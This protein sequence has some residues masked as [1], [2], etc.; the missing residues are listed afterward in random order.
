MK[1][2][3]LNGKLVDSARAN[4]SIFDRGLNYGD[5]LLETMLAVDGRVLFLKEHLKRL[6]AGLKELK[7]K[8]P[9]LDALTRRIN[10]GIIEKLL[11][12][13][14]LL[15]GQAYMRI[16][17]TRGID[18][19]SVLPR[20]PL[21]PTVIIVA[22]PIDIKAAKARG[23]GVAAVLLKDW[24]PAIPSVKTLNYLPN[25]LGKMEAKKRGA[26]EG[27]FTSGEFVLEG[28]STNIFVIKKGVLMTPPL[29]RISGCGILP[30]ITRDVIMRLARANGLKAREKRLRIKD[31]LG[32]EEAF[33]TNSIIGVAPLVKVDGLRVGTGKPGEATRL[34]QNAYGAV[35][36]QLI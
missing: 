31:L 4:I 15:K 14:G 5:G 3:Y 35:T 30:G 36:G 9:A 13:N 24:R 19:G 21:D 7:I 23:S 16:T 1:K 25:L 22:K 26:S 20:G 8:G 32:C 2:V 12:S 17:V 6:G 28:S 11:K 10:G 29:G 33:L 27:I 18:R 34:L